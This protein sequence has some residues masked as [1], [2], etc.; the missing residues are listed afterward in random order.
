MMVNWF[1]FAAMAQTIPDS[2][3][4][5]CID[6]APIPHAEGAFFTSLNIYWLLVIAAG[7]P[8]ADI[9]YAFLR[10]CMSPEMDKLLTLEG[11]V[12]CRTSTWTDPE[13][14]KI[15]PFY[16]RLGELHENARELPAIEAWPQ[17]ASLIDEVIAQVINT[18]IPIRQILEDAQVK[19]QAI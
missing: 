5:G 1:G 14:N 4:R 16:H 12:G 9:S 6:L 7:S 2:A 13:V 10:H 15:I 8:H 17:I 19:A 18:D 11:G 3:I